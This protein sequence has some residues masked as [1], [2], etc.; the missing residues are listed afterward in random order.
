MLDIK[1]IR[2]NADALDA[3][4]KS[5]G[6]E[7]QSATIIAADE[8]RRRLTQTLQDMQSRRNTAS[9]EIG[10]AMAQKDAARAEQLKAE[11]ASIKDTMAAAEAE[12]RAADEALRDLLSRLPNVP[13]ADVPVGADEAANALVR[14]VGEKPV[15]NGTPR[16]HFELGEALGFMDFEAAAKLSGARFT[17]LKG[18]LAR[19][20]RALGQFMLDLHT[21]EHGYT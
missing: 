17:I 9:R 13:L 15:I 2:E 5:R 10:Q 18:P 4:L 14:M 21:Q 20:E 8:T 16:E 7:A 3:A 12:T 19:L 1:W 6:A 11:V